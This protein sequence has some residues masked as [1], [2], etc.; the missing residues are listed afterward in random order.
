MISYTW[1]VTQ[2]GKIVENDT[3]KTLLFISVQKLQL[4]LRHRRIANV[5]ELLAKQK[6]AMTPILIG[7]VALRLTFTTFHSTIIFLVSQ[8]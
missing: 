1:G 4:H 6:I 8:N 3:I 5:A 7:K 2:N